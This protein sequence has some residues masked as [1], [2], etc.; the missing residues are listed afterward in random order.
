MKIIDTQPTKFYHF[1]PA[2][3]AVVVVKYLDKVNGMAVAWNTG[4]SSKPPLFGLLIAPK[5]LTHEM[6]EKAGEF[7]VNFLP[8]EKSEIIAIFGRVSGREMDKIKEYN[9]ELEPSVKI[10]SPIIKDSY[11]SYECKLHKII[12]IGDHSLVIGEVLNVHYEKDAFLDNGLPDLKKITPNLYLGADTYLYLKD[13]EIKVMDK[14]YV[15]KLRK[16]RK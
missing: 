5:R 3:T 16:E 12:P 1:Y 13:F 6:V 4:L 9:I 15:L 8:A 7:S 2:V 14:E 10:N 11:A